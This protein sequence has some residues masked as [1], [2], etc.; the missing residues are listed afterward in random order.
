MD[1]FGCPNVEDGNGNLSQGAYLAEKSIDI[2]YMLAPMAISKIVG[3]STQ[4]C[5]LIDICKNDIRFM[6]T[7]KCE[8]S[9]LKK[10]EENDSC[11]IALFARLYGLEK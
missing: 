4:I 1:E 9:P 6:S 3:E 5:P 2:G 10:K 11:P 7:K 8:N